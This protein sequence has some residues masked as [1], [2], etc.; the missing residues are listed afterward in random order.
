MCEGGC[1]AGFVFFRSCLWEKLTVFL[2]APNLNRICFVFPPLCP[3][4]SLAL[5]F[6]SWELWIKRRI[7]NGEI[8]ARRQTQLAFKWHFFPKRLKAGNKQVGQLWVSVNVLTASRGVNQ[9]RAGA[10]LGASSR[11]LRLRRASNLNSCCLI[12]MTQIL[13]FLSLM[14]RGLQTFSRLFWDSLQSFCQHSCSFLGAIVNNLLLLFAAVLLFRLQFNLQRRSL[15]MNET[16]ILCKIYWRPHHHQMAGC[17]SIIFQVVL[18]KTSL[19]KSLSAAV[20][21]DEVESG[22]WE[23]QTNVLSVH[24]WVQTKQSWFICHFFFFLQTFM[25]RKYENANARLMCSYWKSPSKILPLWRRARPVSCRVM[26]IQWEMSGCEHEMH[27]SL[28]NNQLVTVMD[29][30]NRSETGETD[31]PLLRIPAGCVCSQGQSLKLE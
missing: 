2:W 29:C 21:A 3:W 30:R 27:Q 8:T 23:N 6:C 24:Q 28:I 14:L 19:Q 13:L 20:G 12:Y 26:G 11:G 25:S 5:A 31:R 17:T 4:W 9:R 7:L 10:P 15:A 16:E 1:A 22:A 18:I